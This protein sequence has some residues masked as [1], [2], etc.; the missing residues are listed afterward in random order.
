MI[1]W[2]HIEMKCKLRMRDKFFNYQI[3]IYTQTNKNPEDLNNNVYEN[4]DKAYVMQW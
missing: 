2:I 4:L 3:N 1:R